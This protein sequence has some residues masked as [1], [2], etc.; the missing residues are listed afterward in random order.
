MLYSEFTFRDIFL[1]IKNADR[2]NGTFVTLIQFY[3]LRTK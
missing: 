3:Y 1:N 2:N